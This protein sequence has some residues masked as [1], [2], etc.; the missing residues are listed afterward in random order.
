M[1]AIHLGTGVLTWSR[2]ERIS[3]RYGAIWLMEDGYTSLSTDKPGMLL[4]LKSASEIQGKKGCLVAKVLDPRGST[5]IGDFSLG[6]FPKTPERGEEIK[7]GAGIAFSEPNEDAGT[8]V[9]LE[10][11]DGRANDWLNPEQLY[12][13][14][15]QLVE[16]RFHPDQ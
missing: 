16:L 10:P 8:A 14:H 7:L 5:H 6:I 12:R 11:A 9:G 1:T 3:G 15:E 4:D 13:A 2:G